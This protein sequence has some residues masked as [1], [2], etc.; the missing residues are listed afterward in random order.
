MASALALVAA[1]LCGAV[2]SADINE[3]AKHACRNST[4]FWRDAG[5]PSHIHMDIDETWDD[6]FFNGKTVPCYQEFLTFG[7]E[8]TSIA[9]GNLMD[10]YDRGGDTPTEKKAPCDVPKIVGQKTPC[11]TLKDSLTK[12]TTE[13]VMSYKANNTCGVKITIGFAGKGGWLVGEL[14]PSTDDKE[15]ETVDV[16]KKENTEGFNLRGA[17]GVGAET[18]RIELTDIQLHL[19]CSAPTTAP[20]TAPTAAPTTAPTTAPTAVAPDGTWGGVRPFDCAAHP[21]PIQIFKI[22]I[23]DPLHEVSE[24]NPVTGKYEEVYALKLEQVKGLDNTKTA[25]VN[26]AAMLAYDDG[27]GGPLRH[28]AL[29]QLNGKLC[30]F[31][32][33]L[34]HR[35][36]VAEDVD[37][38]DFS[39]DAGNYVTRR[40]LGDL[41]T[42]TKQ[43]SVDVSA[44][45]LVRGAER[46]APGAYTYY[47]SCATCGDYRGPQ[48]IYAVFD[49][50]PGG[51]PRFSTLEDLPLRM[52]S[53]LWTGGSSKGNIYDWAALG[54]RG[55]EVLVDDGRDG[56]SYLV[57]VNPR[58]DRLVV[59]RIDAA[60][61][62]A[63][64]YAVLPLVVDWND[65]LPL[66]AA[67]DP[68]GGRTAKAS[69]MGASFAYV[70]GGAGAGGSRVFFT[71]N[72]GWGLFELSLPVEVHHSCW[73]D[74]GDA[75]NHALCD[76]EVWYKRSAA[77][78]RR[79]L[80]HAGF[81]AVLVYRTPSVATGFND[82]MNCRLEPDE[83]LDVVETWAPAATP[84]PTP[85]PVTDFPTPAEAKSPEPTTVPTPEPTRPPSP[86]DARTPGPTAAPTAA[87]TEAPTAAPTGAPT[88]APTAAPTEAPTAAPTA[89]PTEDPRFWRGIEAFDCEKHR[90][91]IQV[92][93]GGSGETLHRVVELDLESGQYVEIYQIDVPIRLRVSSEPPGY[94]AGQHKRATC[95]TSKAPTSAGL[96]SFRLI[97][98]RAIISRD[99]L[100]AWM[101]FSGTRARGT[102][103]LKRR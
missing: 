27:R 11:R 12:D 37:G 9:D 96:R 39:H 2:A 94:A 95:P 13:Y 103:T 35:A 54:E 86:A 49:V 83:A 56:E 61:G 20:T 15:V 57:G 92:L 69:P 84:L 90:N 81:G 58:V 44:G 97:F 14:P 3:W 82:G 102:L 59:V 41:Q 7:V 1:A 66:P 33:T 68:P 24:L 5:L 89:A 40:C 91:P 45:A 71:S 101:L 28:Y 88:A 42:S 100:A 67:W 29:A 36:A 55:G 34:T 46:S 16:V 19:A 31:D 38:V 43:R 21:N 53:A 6:C 65:R 62:H 47:Y 18:C 80:F 64:A 26:G 76:G 50:G 10:W 73:Y 70:G 52:N 32:E 99:G 72:V 85:S 87:P 63:G 78:G 48:K 79:R 93:K 98:G 25:T 22:N 51:S 60:T 77:P 8:A 17:N 4:D 74:G 30:F 75:E 23:E